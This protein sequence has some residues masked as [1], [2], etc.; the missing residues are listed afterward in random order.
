MYKTDD[1]ISAIL[2]AKLNRDRPVRLGGRV[3]TAVK[4]MIEIT[5]DEWTALVQK[6]PD[7]KNLTIW[8][9]CLRNRE[10]RPEHI[11]ALTATVYNLE[12]WDEVNPCA[13]VYV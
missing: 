7:D 5:T 10:T 1:P 13:R 8:D 4:Q 3:D 9:L 12:G 11:V 6:Y 2:I